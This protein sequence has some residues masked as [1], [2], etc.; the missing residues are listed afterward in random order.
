[1]KVKKD[2]LMRDLIKEV[3]QLYDIPCES[4]VIMKR[5]PMMNLQ[6]IDML[7]N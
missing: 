2:M 1:M 6:S 7:S 3:S 4:V 5:N